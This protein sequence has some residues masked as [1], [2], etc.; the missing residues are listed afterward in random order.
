MYFVI[1]F[2]IQKAIEYYSGHLLLHK[3]LPPN[4][5]LY[6]SH[7]FI[8]CYNF[9]GQEFRK[10]LSEQ[11]LCVMR[12]QQKALDGILMMAGLLQRAQASLTY[13]S[14]ILLEM[15]RRIGSTGQLTAAPMCGLCNTVV[16]E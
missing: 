12:D 3:K 11:V 2:Y 9:M 13:I 5:V 7:Y 6:N 15:A 14:G 16:L 8:T 1:H 4:F 10:G